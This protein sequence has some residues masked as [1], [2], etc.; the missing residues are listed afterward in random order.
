MRKKLIAGLG[1]L[2]ACG[3]PVKKDINLELDNIEPIEMMANLEYQGEVRTFVAEPFYDF[4]WNSLC[5]VLGGVTVYEYKTLDPF[6][7]FWDSDHDGSLN[8]YMP[9][10]ENGLTLDNGKLFF[11]MV[12]KNYP[13]FICED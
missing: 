3:T 8:G 9:Q 2:L 12:K 4:D 6:Y 1:I 11:D 10:I 13:R 5:T 7:T